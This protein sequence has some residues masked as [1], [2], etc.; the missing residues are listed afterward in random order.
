MGTCVIIP[1]QAVERAKGCAV[2]FCR[3]HCV[4]AETSLEGHAVTSDG[5]CLGELRWSGCFRD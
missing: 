4:W 2:L 5:R 1:R 3:S